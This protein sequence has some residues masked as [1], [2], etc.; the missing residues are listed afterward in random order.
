[1]KNVLSTLI[2]F[3]LH[4]QAVFAQTATG[5]VYHDL[6]KNGRKDAREPGIANV[7]VSNGKEVVKT[8]KNGKWTL[9]VGD[10]TGFFVIKPAEYS[11]P[12]TAD[13]LPKNY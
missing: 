4:H 12:L 13:N 1:M 6:N 10:D 7:C 3:L 5:T 2:L 11:V 9:P 8:D